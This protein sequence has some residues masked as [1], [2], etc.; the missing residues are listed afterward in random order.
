LHKY[1]NLL[2]FVWVIAWMVESQAAF[3][4]WE[5]KLGN[6]RL[7]EVPLLTELKGKV[8]DRAVQLKA[9]TA[10]IRVKKVVFVKAKVYVAELLASTPEKFQ[11]DEASALTSLQ[12]MDSVAMKL[13][14]LRDVEAKSFRGAFLDG[15]KENKISENDPWAKNF[16]EKILVLGEQKKGA[17][18]LILASKSK[19]G[20]LILVDNFNDKQLLF[21]AQPDDRRKVFSLWFGQPADSG[22]QDLKAKLLG[23][24]K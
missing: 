12:E 6:E 22:L 13:T 19:G 24:E 5:P 18:L 8:E 21:P 15:W 3:G 4:G 9:V 10:G 17:Q 7:E 1:M 14:F 2:V 20:D 11:K 16:L 23:K